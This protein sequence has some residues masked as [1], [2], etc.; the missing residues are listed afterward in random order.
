MAIRTGMEFHGT[1]W[2]VDDFQGADPPDVLTVA[3]GV[4]GSDLVEQ[5]FRSN[6]R[7][8]LGSSLFHL[9]MRSHEAA[10]LEWPCLM[11]MIFLDAGHSAED[12]R[13]DIDLWWPL[14]KEGGVLCGHDYG[15]SMFPGIQVEVDSFAEKKGLSVVAPADTLLWAITK[16]THQPV[17]A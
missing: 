15:V 17:E 12:V 13:C 7:E 14:L 11:D 8:Y 9:K 3:A 2:C 5:V 4:V 10:A 16:V 1:L 6:C